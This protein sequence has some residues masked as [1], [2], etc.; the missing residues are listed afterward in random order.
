MKYISISTALGMNQNLFVQ[1]AQQAL[2]CN[3][4]VQ[5]HSGAASNNR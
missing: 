5:S 3:L 4:K 1:I 2:G